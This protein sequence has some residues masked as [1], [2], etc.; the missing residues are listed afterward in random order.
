MRTKDKIC[1]CL[2]SGI[3][4]FQ[5]KIL[6]TK[7]MQEITMLHEL[8]LRE[9]NLCVRLIITTITFLCCII[10]WCNKFVRY[11]TQTITIF[12]R[13]LLCIQFTWRRKK[14]FICTVYFSSSQTSVFLSFSEHKI[15]AFRYKT[16]PDKTKTVQCAVEPLP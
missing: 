4:L 3:I 13:T 1:M 14:R 10:F 16:K 6:S 7:I 8:F 15:I 12:Y 2:Q 5:Y 9:P 11:A